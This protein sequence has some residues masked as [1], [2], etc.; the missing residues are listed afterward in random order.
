MQTRRQTS[1]RWDTGILKQMTARPP[2]V[3]VSATTAADYDYPAT[4]DAVAGTHFATSAK[5]LGVLRCW[6]ALLDPG[7][8]IL[9]L[10]K[11]GA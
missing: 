4:R 6:S 5:F 8:R 2:V 9:N 10:R 11:S 7:E 1:L 3:A